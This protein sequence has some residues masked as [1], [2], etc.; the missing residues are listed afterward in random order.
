MV[1][2]DSFAFVIHRAPLGA[3]RETARAFLSWRCV[4]PGEFSSSGLPP[5]EKIPNRPTPRLRIV[6]PIVPYADIVFVSNIEVIMF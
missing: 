6:G 2:H 5:L 3:E 4:W 1:R